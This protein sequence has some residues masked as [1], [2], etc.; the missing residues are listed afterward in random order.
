MC[1]NP[2]DLSELTILNYI[3]VFTAVLPNHEFIHCPPLRSDEV[4]PLNRIQLKLVAPVFNAC[5]MLTEYLCDS[6]HE[7]AMCPFDRLQSTQFGATDL[8]IDFVNEPEVID[9]ADHLLY[10]VCSN[11]SITFFPPPQ[12]FNHLQS[13]CA[14]ILVLQFI[15]LVLPHINWSSVKGYFSQRLSGVPHDTPLIRD[16][17]LEFLCRTC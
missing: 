9:E 12:S 4:D 8:F 7:Q 17:Q 3:L 6:R 13:I 15:L 2:L 10:A 14:P 1:S 5:Q 11:R 16:T